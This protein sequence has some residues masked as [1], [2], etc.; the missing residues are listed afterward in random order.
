MSYYVFKNAQKGAY[1]VPCS[2]ATVTS[3]KTKS[4]AIVDDKP[5][6]IVEDFILLVHNQRVDYVKE[7]NLRIVATVEEA[8]KTFKEF[9]AEIEAA[10]KA[11]EA[12]K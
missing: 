11:K 5:Q 10:I 9:I 2:L 6:I 3:A 4:E 7:E 1:I 12:T 8:M